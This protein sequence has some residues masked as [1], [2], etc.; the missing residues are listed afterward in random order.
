[1]MLIWLSLSRIFVFGT[2]IRASAYVILNIHPCFSNRVPSN[3]IITTI[4]ILRMRCVIYFLLAALENRHNW[5][6]ALEKD[7]DDD[8]KLSSR[9]QPFNDNYLT[10]LYLLE[11]EQFAC[12]CVYHY[13]NKWSFGLEFFPLQSWAA[14]VF[15]ALSRRS[16]IR[17]T[18]LSTFNLCSSRCECVCF[19]SPFQSLRVNCIPFSIAQQ[20]AGTWFRFILTPFVNQDWWCLCT[21]WIMIR[22]I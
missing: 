7:D 3:L 18:P 8:L 12:E 20:N 22:L 1:M 10:Y 19:H 11:D 14:G 17:R 15:L 21:R 9:R 2:C 4:R 16:C 13:W 6:K 5:R